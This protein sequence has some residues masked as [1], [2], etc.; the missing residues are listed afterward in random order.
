[1]GGGGGTR[2]VL[3]S[4]REELLA[5]GVRAR[6]GEFTP[7]ATGEGVEPCKAKLPA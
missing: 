1:M 4:E 3:A 7:E 6:T 5:V 2:R